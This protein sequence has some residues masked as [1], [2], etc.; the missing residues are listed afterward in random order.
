MNEFPQ[1]NAG[2]YKQQ[3]SAEQEN[4]G[5]IKAK[6]HIVEVFGLQVDKPD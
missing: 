3:Q 5:E 6:F 4:R 1:L 2:K